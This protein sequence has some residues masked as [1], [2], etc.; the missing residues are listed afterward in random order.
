MSITRH[1]QQLTRR[2]NDPNRIVCIRKHTPFCLTLLPM[3]FTQ[4]TQLPESLVRSYRTVSPL[5]GKSLPTSPHNTLRKGCYSGGLLSAALALAAELVSG[6]SALPTTL[7]CGARTFLPPKFS[8]RPATI[9][10]APNVGLRIL[11]FP[12]CHT[13]T[14]RKES[15][16]RLPSHRRIAYFCSS[17]RLQTL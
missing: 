4:P 9:P 15:R 8:L 11:L 7:L 16:I 2:S 12:V 6:R 5:P 14:Y 17:T 13:R 3:G 1:L 10:P